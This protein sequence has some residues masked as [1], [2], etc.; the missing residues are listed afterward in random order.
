MRKYFSISL[1]LLGLTFSGFLIANNFSDHFNF[2]S[3]NT[4]PVITCPT[5][6]TTS[7]SGSACE[8]VVTYTT[9]TV[10]D[11]DAGLVPTLVSGPASGASLAQ[12]NYLVTYSITDS[13][14]L[15]STCSF[16]ITVNPATDVS[17]ALSCAAHINLSLDEDC[18]AEVTPNMLLTSTLHAC[19]DRYQVTL[20]HS[21]SGP[22]T[23]APFVD[24]S[25]YG[26]TLY[27]K[28]YDP[29]TTNS[30]WGSILVEDKLPPILNCTNN[31]FECFYKDS[32]IQA[33][34]LHDVDSLVHFGV[35]LPTW[36][37][38]CGT[39]N[40]TVNYL[41]INSEPCIADTINLQ[42]IITERS[43]LSDT[44][45]S[46]IYLTPLDINSP[47]L[48]FPDNVVI[49]CSDV[50]GTTPLYT[51][52]ITYNGKKM[53]SGAYCNFGITYS[54]TVIELC[55][56][57]TKKILRN[58]TIYDWCNNVVRQHL[59]V[60]KIQDTRGPSIIAVTPQQISNHFQCGKNVVLYK[61]TINDACNSAPYT[62]TWQVTL[63]SDLGCAVPGQNIPT[64]LVLQ[65]SF[66][67]NS[68]SVFLPTGSH[69]IRYSAIDACG[70]L[71]EVNQPITVVDD[72]TPTAVCQE[73]TQ[74][75]LSNG[76]S[77]V[78]RAEAFN[79][80]STDN[81]GI[82]GYKVKFMN[83]SDAAFRDSLLLTS[84]Y[85][86]VY[87]G[88]NINLS[89]GSKLV[90]MRVYDCAGNTNDCMVEVLIDDKVKPIMTINPIKTFCCDDPLFINANI[91]DNI[92]SLF[93][94]P[95]YQD[96]C[97]ATLE[98]LPIQGSLDQCGNGFY[99]KKWRA[100]DKCNNETFIS[101]KIN[102]IHR[103]DFEV[104][105]PAND[106]LQCASSDEL[107]NPTAVELGGTGIPILTDEDCEVVAISHQDEIFEQVQNACYKIVRTWKVI[108]WCKFTGGIPTSSDD[109][110]L[111]APRTY[112]DGGITN[113]PSLG[114][115]GFMQ[116]VQVIM[117]RD[118][119]APNFVSKT[120]PSA[121]SGNGTN[122]NPF[123]FST[124]QSDCNLTDVD[125]NCTGNVVITAIAEDSCAGNQTLQYSWFVDLNVDST[126][127]YYSA[128][129][130]SLN[131]YSQTNIPIGTHRIVFSA[132]DGCGN[133]T[134]CDVYFEV[135]DTKKP[136][137]VCFGSLAIDLMPTTGT[138]VMWA[139]DFVTESSC[140]NCTN[141]ENL[142]YRVRKLVDG[143]AAPTTVPTENNVQFSCDDLGFVFVQVW[144][145]D[146]SNNWDYCTTLVSVQNNM[147]A[148]CPGSNT[149]DIAGF[150]QTENLQNVSNVN[151][152][153]SNGMQ[154]LTNNAGIYQFLGIPYGINVLVQ[155]DK[156]NDP[157]NGVTTLDLVLISKHIL[158]I[159][160]LGSPYK[161]IA[162]DI[163]KTKNITT[164]D[165][166]E[167]R[168]LILNINSTFT[169]NHSWRFVSKDYQFI[170]P[171]NALTEN[172]P[173][174]I[175]INQFNGSLADA[176]FVAVKVGDVNNSAIT[177][178]NASGSNN[179]HTNA[180]TSI[181]FDKVNYK[182]GDLVHLR[183]K[184]DHEQFIALQGTL[185][186]NTNEL[187]FYRLESKVEF[188]NVEKADEG[189]ILFSIDHVAS[190]KEE[191]DIDIEF[192]ALADG[193]LSD[194]IELSDRYL[195]SEAYQKDLT[196]TCNLR[197]DFGAQK[198][199]NEVVLYQNEPNPF[200]NETTV[201][202]YLPNAEQVN[203][204]IRDLSGKVLKQLEINGE[205][206]MN[207]VK[208]KK[209][210]FSD[211]GIYFYQ[212]NSL[213]SS[214]TK[215]MIFFNN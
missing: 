172:F 137:P 2:S 121:V 59:Q 176:N 96:N 11:E 177:N 205:L 111:I 55:G 82:V 140:D 185:K 50:I 37:Q 193:S 17:A 8:A 38:V 195:S 99:I 144:V 78:V 7:L 106:T 153:L 29:V 159:Q 58:W 65:G 174:I 98:E 184:I 5:N 136:T 115:D 109:D 112:K 126:P 180:T 157:L 39:Y 214:L 211:N 161:L 189:T 49:E 90:V 3:P 105:F 215:K 168:K 21:A 101:Q 158:G 141:R 48:L 84:D 80:A 210:D 74:V 152:N 41:G 19:Y 88:S 206:G 204:I 71:T 24:E 122:V 63:G 169:N 30:C 104:T 134:T 36:T 60:I 175:N 197:A 135:K 103:S 93:D 162:A 199:N 198:N 45:E 22:F 163:N 14:N 130:E 31:S 42:W 27:Y 165:I 91:T 64:D 127:D 28:L 53:V 10:T 209:S 26:Q 61:P 132:S 85:L 20:S 170:D 52:A 128:S 167:L 81:C 192:I 16:T 47:L 40:L 76:C 67:G 4:A 183:G 70:N 33:A 35:T 182:K 160:A 95:F 145:G 190:S 166:V 92:N 83:E 15:T 194:D 191:N 54:D 149:G 129:N 73:L 116:Y 97:S 43:G 13:E 57:N 179:R 56:P 46:Q 186:F 117:V 119:V 44:C 200:T 208:L 133:L 86:G 196:T 100:Y 51:G 154:Y 202:F 181:K 124:S 113:C 34:L 108:N 25:F 23:L 164:L 9:P 120:A 139:S 68:A 147:G 173:E 12:G 156:N 69:I 79:E 155:P 123:V 146:E 201:N 1:Y 87:E 66:V 203:L 114:G 62:V 110:V 148:N 188:F 143:E 102:V 107:L 75:T 18:N 89:C 72:V 32:L 151:I 131:T 94:T 77:A 178:L 125:L 118:E 6:I 142:R 171:S 207:S 187:S 212:L 138:V 150:I 213:N